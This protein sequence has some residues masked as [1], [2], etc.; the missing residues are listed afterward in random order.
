[1]T[2]PPFATSSFLATRRGKLVLAFLCAVAFLDFLDTS[3]VNVA[4]PS[5]SRD[6]HFSVQNLQWVLSGYIVTYGGFLLLGGRLADLLGRRLI[7]MTGTALFG[8]ASLVGGLAQDSGMLIGAR[9]AEGLGAALMSPAALSILT[10]R[11]SYGTDRV[12]ALGAWGA[13]GGIAAVAGVFLGGVLSAGPGWRWVLFVNLPV[14]AL[15]LVATFRLI[16]GGRPGPSGGRDLHLATFDTPGAILGTGGMLLLIFALV[17][18][19]DNGWGAASTVGELTAAGVLLLAFGVNETRQRHPLVPPSIFRLKGLAAANTSQVIAMA[20]FYSVFFFITLYMQNVLGFS[21]LRAGSAYV[22]VALMV[23]ISAGIGTVL[24]PRTGSRPL[25]V[26]GAL[27][28]AGGVY[29]LSRIPVH[30]YYWTDLF[31]G[32]VI[33]AFGLGGVFVGVQTAANAGV[34]PSLAGLAG[35]L[36]NASTQ[37][38]AALGLAIFSALATSRTN[39]LLAV[40]AAPDV[41]ATSGFHQALLAASIFLAATAFIALR[42]TNTRGEPTSEITGTLAEDAV[43][44]RRTERGVPERGAAS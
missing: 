36:I 22:P 33:M 30:G 41:A 19:P 11:F 27:I 32:L 25:M 23:A 9:L 44:S 6:L 4:L 5:I 7:L 2:A 39:S 28:S 3:I 31:P 34:P 20:G 10:T 42:A 14:C 13:M 43:R 17:R 29:W 16:D 8:A 21:P 18:A 15:V 37:V 35:A 12:K 24:I 1:M 40:H 38:G 26:A